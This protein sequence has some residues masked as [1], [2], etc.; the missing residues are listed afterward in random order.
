[1]HPKEAKLKLARTIV[2]QFYSDADA[3]DAQ[4]NFEH[5]FSRKQVPE[6]AKEYIVRGSSPALVD[7]MVEA[8]LAASKNEARR[9]IQQGAV[10]LAGEK[11]SGEN[12]PVKAGILKVGKRRFV[13]LTQD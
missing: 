10:T 12:W 8:K 13:R 9:L 3:K 7:I 1:M 5:T 11:V 4:R 6:D 2:A